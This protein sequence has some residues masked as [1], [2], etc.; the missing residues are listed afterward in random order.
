MPAVVDLTT[1]DE[2]EVSEWCH[3]DNS[4]THPRQRGLQ[5]WK[6]RLGCGEGLG[7]RIEGARTIEGWRQ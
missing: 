3:V 2:G 5:P 6:A 1:E 4:I 7:T